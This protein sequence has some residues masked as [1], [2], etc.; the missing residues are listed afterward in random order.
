MDAD[1]PKLRRIRRLSWVCTLSPLVI[2]L[3]FMVLGV[4]ARIELGHWLEYA[5]RFTPSP[6]FAL[7][8]NLADWLMVAVVFGAFP[9]WVACHHFG[10]RRGDM[11]RTFWV[12]VF[13]YAFAWFVAFWWTAYDPTG[14]GVWFLD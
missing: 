9:G 6:A 13:A 4:A 5:E 14:Y 8:E 10:W 3:L 11:S 1:D 2:P 7:R 12:Q